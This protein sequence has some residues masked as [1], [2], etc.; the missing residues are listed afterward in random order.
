MQIVLES[1]PGTYIH[2][3]VLSN[4]GTVSCSS[5]QHEPLME[6][7][8]RLI[9]SQT[10]CPPATKPNKRAAILL[11]CITIEMAVRSISRKT[12]FE[13]TNSHTC[14]FKRTKKT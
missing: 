7:K 5:K 9:M 4:V 10:H 14:T 2:V 13:N 11:D 8:L 6:L 1:V 3:P 12:K